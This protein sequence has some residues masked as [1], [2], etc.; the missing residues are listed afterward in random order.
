ME[1]ERSQDPSAL[2]VIFVGESSTGKTSLINNLF[3]IE[4]DPSQPSTCIPHQQVY[5]LQMPSSDE[6][7]LSLWDTA[8]QEKFRS[9]NKLFFK[10]AKIAIIVIDITQKHTFLALDEFWFKY[11]K[12][13]CGEHCVIGIAENKVDLFEKE[14]VSEKD[15]QD[16][17]Q[18]KDILTERTSAVTGVG[19]EDLLI[20]LVE[21]Y[22]YLVETK[23]I[24]DTLHNS[25]AKVN[26]GG[27][28]KKDKCC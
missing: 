27:N 6:V 8:G 7:L 10:N 14:E 23:V 2:K 3:H 25:T 28:G 12:E 22:L 5:H 1:F 4:I 26:H 15:V 13:I 18:D 24:P 19:I 21:R 17:I 16:Y 9:L 11:I 20:K